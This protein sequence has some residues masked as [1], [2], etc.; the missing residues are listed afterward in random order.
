MDKNIFQ[1]LL[2]GGQCVQTDEHLAVINPYTQECIGYAGSATPMQMEDAIH[3]AASYV[4]SLSRYQRSLILGQA[5]ELVK[6]RADQLAYQVIAESGLCWKDAMNEVC[7]TQDVFS[8][9]AALS[10]QEDGE[11]FAG[12]ISAHGK[13]RKIIAL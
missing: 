11:L 13:N 12:D 5:A 4:P 10:I 8:I 3:I 6:E 1:P 9:A 2:I 7:R